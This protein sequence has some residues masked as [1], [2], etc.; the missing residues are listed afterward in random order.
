MRTAPMRFSTDPQK[1]PRSCIIVSIPH[2]KRM[3]VHEVYLRLVDVTNVEWQ[4]RAQFLVIAAQ[5]MRRILVDSARTRGLRRRRGGTGQSESA[6]IRC[7]VALARP[8]DPR[9]GRGFDNVLS[10]STAPGEGGGARRSSKDF[11]A[12][13]R[14]R[15]GS[16]Q[17]LVAAR[18][19]PYS[20]RSSGFQA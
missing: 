6:C 16:H 15:L 13:R 9:P 4:E 5:I 7:F 18:V 17:G 12:D 11:A 8:F 10:A 14:A 3:L 20:R 19:K 1:R 2:R